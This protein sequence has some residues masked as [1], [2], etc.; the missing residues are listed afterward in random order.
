MKFTKKQQLLINKLLTLIKNNNLHIQYEQT[1]QKKLMMYEINNKDNLPSK[2]HLEL[3]LSC[4]KN[5]DGYMSENIMFSEELISN[6]IIDDIKTIFKV[7]HL[8]DNCKNISYMLSIFKKMKI[9]CQ[10]IG[11][12]KKQYNRIDSKFCINRYK[13]SEEDYSI[14]GLHKS[15]FH[16]FGN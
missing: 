11:I 13:S 3:Q 10:F 4:Y 7:G 15:A 2:Q 1:F 6:E 14:W 16:T 5:N 12:M 8:D 9:N